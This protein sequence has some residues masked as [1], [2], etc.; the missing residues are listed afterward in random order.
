MTAQQQQPSYCDYIP[1]K[2]DPDATWFRYHFVGKPYRTFIGVMHNADNNSIMSSDTIASDKK[3]GRK[4]SA[5]KNKSSGDNS[6]RS[7]SLSNDNNNDQY[8]NHIND[9]EDSSSMAI[10]SVIQER[11]RDF[12]GLGN[13][14]ASIL[15]TQ[16]RII[17]RTKKPE[18]GRYIIH[19][20][21]AKETR[22]RL[23]KLN[24]GYRLEKTSLSDRRSGKPFASKNK[25]RCSISSSSSNTGDNSIDNSQSS[26]MLRAA[27]LTV[28]PDVDLQYFKE[29]SA[30]ST[31]MAGLE[32]D[33]LKYD[34]LHIPKRYKFGVL[35]IRDNQTT[36]EAWFSNTGLSRE[37]HHFLA[38]MGR[39][40]ELKGY[41][42]YAAGLDTKTG[43]SGK[44]AYISKWNNF[45]IVFHV[46]P[47]MPSQ[48]NDR[49]QV[50]RKKHIGND[51]V[52]I[53]FLEGSGKQ[54]FNPEAIR[55]QF[56]HV[57]IIVRPET[58][59]GRKFWRVEVVRKSGIKD[60][61]PPLPSPPVFYDDATLK[62]YL[63]V[64]LINA[65][66]AAL[67]SEKFFIPNN[68]ARLGLLATHLQTGI[69]FNRPQVTRSVSTHRL[70]STDS[71]IAKSFYHTADEQ[72]FF[73]WQQQQQQKHIA[74]RPKSAAD[75]PLHGRSSQEHTILSSYRLSHTAID[76]ANDI[77]Y[78][79]MNITAPNIDSI[80]PMPQVSK[81]TLLQDLKKGMRSS[82]KIF[83]NN[84]TN[85][86]GS[87]SSYAERN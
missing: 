64:K 82:T 68:R 47:M 36:E 72:I 41:T 19:E 4:L 11:A 84:K 69:S 56:L 7:S 81:S 58:S 62:D 15:G 9:T 43:E 85:S 40:V 17:V 12:A 66:N 87:N 80:P 29:L 25:D 5:S 71:D 33:L 1:D 67:K 44:Y 18:Q 75:K 55:S 46:A 39:K 34:E 50:L 10:V 83:K 57:Y 37:L 30:E 27:L 24:K 48:M 65:E 16:Y 70:T 60:F 26:K 54:K 14:A 8:R 2:I 63:T 42:G 78:L 20:S 45:D 32:K 76:A 53:I 49:Q 79:K 31:I 77:D 38:T 22:M 6:S 3:V 59:G 28:C 13:S 52:C 23:E 74:Q 61:G 21:M 73:S 51:I 35:T 86:S